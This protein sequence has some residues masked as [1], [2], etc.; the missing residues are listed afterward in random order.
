MALTPAQRTTLRNDILAD[1]ALAAQPK[2]AERRKEYR[3]RPPFAPSLRELL[4]AIRRA[5]KRAKDP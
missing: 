1:P 4:A 5:K 2:T 3:P